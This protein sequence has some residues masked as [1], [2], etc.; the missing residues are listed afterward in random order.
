MAPRAKFAAILG[1][2]MSAPASLKCGWT[3]ATARSCR[4][5][6]VPMLD[7]QAV[8]HPQDVPVEAMYLDKMHPTAR[9]QEALARALQD[10]LA[11]RKLLPETGS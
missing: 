5:T 3:P 8:L 4:E 2:L 7:A 1:F 9:G 6:G 11:S 10:F